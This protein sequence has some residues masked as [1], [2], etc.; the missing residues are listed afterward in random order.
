MSASQPATELPKNYD[1]KTVEARLYRTWEAAGYF[2]E[3]PDPARPPFIICMPPPNV[4]GRAHLGHGSTYTPMDALVR[5]HRMLGDNAD[6]LPGLDHAAIAT[7]AVVIKELAKDGLTRESLGREAYIER[8]WAW[9]REY[10]GTI[11]E[12]FRAL[13]FGP[14]WSRER[15]T[16]DEGLSRAVRKVFVEMYREGLVYR[17][18]RLINWD[19]KARTTV[20]DAEVDHIERDAFL[21]RVRYPLALR[22]GEDALRQAQ[23]DRGVAQGER[24]YIEVAT[25]RPETML[26]DVAIAVHPDDARYAGLVGKTVL[27]PPLL[28]RE[29][30]IVAD[31]AVEMDFGTGAVK[32]TPAHDATDYAI[33]QRHNLPMPSVLDLDARITGDD[34]PVGRY[35]GMDRFDA[36]QAI[37]DDLRAQ[38]TLVEQ[39][40]YR[41]AV[42]VS[43]RTGEV[44]EPLLSEQ[45]FVTMKPLAEPALKAYYDGRIRFV[46]ERYGRTYEQWLENIRDWNISRQVWWGHQLP[47][48]YTAD[49]EIVVAETEEEARDIARSRFGENV[50]LR[51]DPDTLDT[52]FSSALWP[53]SILGWPERTPELEAWYPSQVLVTGWE[54]I[55]LWVAR[56][57]MLGLKFMGSVPFPDV[58]VAPL[59]FDAQGRK[60][61][62]SL[63][64][65]I[66]PLAL[67]DK[68]GADAFR[69]GMMRQLRLEGQEVRFQESRCEEARN[70]N[71][72]IWNATRYVL[73][74][75][76]GLPRA[77]TLPPAAALTPADAWILTRLY[78]AVNATSANFDRYDFGSAA[79][80]V[81]KFIWYEFCD[82]Y[83]EAT[84]TEDAK[85]TRAAV[86]SFVLNNAV[87]LLHPIE[88]F[89]TEE[90]W[91]ALPHDGQ[92]ITTASWPDPEEIP[93]DRVAAERFEAILEAVGT[94]RNMRSELGF[95]P[96]ARM[97]C[98]VPDVLPDD[99]VTAFAA[100]AN[101][102]PNR[103]AAQ[104]N[105]L[106]VRD[107]LRMCRP[108]VSDAF[109]RD[110]YRR[111]AERLAA[112][113]ERGEKKLANQKFVANAKGDV[114]AKE[115][116]KLESYRSDLARVRE[117]LHAMGA[118]E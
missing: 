115:R 95:D 56:M 85:A 5:Y 75:P 101:I 90:V 65:A 48:W 116:E 57:T 72:K 106:S 97:D 12:Q 9:A 53:F 77:R 99:V 22:Q 3:E 79:D 73:S 46:P 69:M 66:D 42:S 111:D 89:I 60:M 83:L 7:E 68:F 54:I 40:A 81:W 34:V 16:M 13:G 104:T 59:V 58:F 71:N 112:E 33:G 74:L 44:I 103:I 93:V 10:G 113:V 29:I 32:V 52:W 6:W 20:S 36:R 98:D 25:T 63:G 117:A 21:W 1:P 96:R 107:L 100:L 2:H 108:K 4:T 41:Q 114:V 62:K 11:D 30:P 64:N 27:V 92:S 86:L 43:E 37:V 49:G 88:P 78:D 24:E 28:E 50:E 80:T 70:F 102:N 45:W 109:M 47:V 67:V 14:D 82:W 26:G 19:P 23:D 18:K 38:G 94:V 39:Q 87:R 76:E 8:A 17:G 105:G 35:A 118:N 31:A 84:K 55:F 110:R 51:R 91:L 15:F 61:S